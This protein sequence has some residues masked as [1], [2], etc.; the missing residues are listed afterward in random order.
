MRGRRGEH[1]R[2]D[3]VDLVVDAAE[4][5]AAA[6]G[7]RGLA[8]R[9]IATA[10]GYAPNSIYNAVG[11]LDDIV[12]KVNAR[13]LARLRGALASALKPGSAPR[14]AILTLADAYLDFVLAHRQVWSLLFEHSLAA[15][16]PWPG[17]YADELAR[18]TLVVGDVLAPLVPDPTARG[19]LVA[20]LWAALH[21]IASLA[22]SDKLGAVTPA[23]PH[24][25]G[26]LMV[27][28]CLDGIAAGKRPARA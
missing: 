5:I 23:D 17:W 26:R 8:L 18:T 14:D 9:R 21:G 12:L 4:G 16:R 2:D 20:A 11:D 15:D 13:T 25:L 3:F 27:G 24:R 7:L 1:S 22:A 28:S 10:I 6:E 19:E